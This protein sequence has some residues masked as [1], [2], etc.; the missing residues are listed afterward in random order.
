M[1]LSWSHWPKTLQPNLK[2]IF[3]SKLHNATSHNSSLAQCAAEWWLTK[4]C[5]KRANYAFSEKFWIRPKSGFLTH[6]FG[7]RYASKSIQGSIDADVDL[8]FN[9]TLSQFLSQK[10]LSQ[11]FESLLFDRVFSEL[12]GRNFNPQLFTYRSWFEAFLWLLIGDGG[13][14]TL[15]VRYLHITTAVG[16]PF[17]SKVLAHNSYSW[18]PFESKVIKHYNCCWGLPWKQGAYIFQL[19]L[20][21][22]LQAKYLQ[23]VVCLRPLQWSLKVEYLHISVPV[24]DPFESKLPGHYSFCKGDLWKQSTCALQFL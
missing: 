8:V 15:K 5:P 6:N 21:V 7:Y 4:I 24:G 14:A 9:K 2:K 23:I 17:E 22:P 1:S 11:N 19:L 13:G 18:G 12:F 10:T 16:G 3:Y 20:K